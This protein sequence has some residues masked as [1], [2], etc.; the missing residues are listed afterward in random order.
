MASEKAHA[1]WETNI[2]MEYPIISPFLMGNT[3][4]GPFSIAMQFF[5][6]GKL[7]CQ[8]AMFIYGIGMNWGLML[9]KRGK[10]FFWHQNSRVYEEE[11]YEQLWAPTSR[12]TGCLV[13]IL[14][15]GYES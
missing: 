8:N 3:S 2:A 4:K 5:G 13:G 7:M 11:S 14:G 6:D 9:F 10:V 1:P 15:D 12:G